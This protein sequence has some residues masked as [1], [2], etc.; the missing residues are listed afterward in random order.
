MAV[1]QTRPDS[2]LQVAGFQVTR[3]EFNALYIELVKSLHKIEARTGLKRKTETD[4]ATMV[5]V[6]LNVRLN[7][8]RNV[9]YMGWYLQNTKAST[10]RCRFWRD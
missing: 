8:S 9:V 10:P 6:D 4:L 5:N 7:S 2:E 1:I 3:S